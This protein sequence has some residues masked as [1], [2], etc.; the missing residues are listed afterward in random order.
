MQES[1]SIEDR[2]QRILQDPASESGLRK[3]VLLEY[4]EFIACQ[5][6]NRMINLLERALI[7]RREKLEKI[8]YD[9]EGDAMYKQLKDRLI[10]ARAQRMRDLLDD[11]DVQ[12]R[13]EASL[14]SNTTTSSDDKTH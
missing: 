6:Y 1:H 8:G 5:R 4:I 9:P 12:R 13:W 3:S 10:L 7:S 14:P 2:V 11:P